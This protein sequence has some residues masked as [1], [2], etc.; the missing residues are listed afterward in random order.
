MS[1]LPVSWAMATAQPLCRR[2]PWE[3]VGYYLVEDAVI[4]EGEVHAGQRY[5]YSSANGY[6]GS[7]MDQTYQRF[8][9]S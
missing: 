6:M 9:E 4:A 7:M 1:V 3:V 8:S 5:S 2:E